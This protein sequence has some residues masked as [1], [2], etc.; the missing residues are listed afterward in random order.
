MSNIT[1][2][3]VDVLMPFLGGYNLKLTASEISK[4]M[5]IPQQTVSR[6]LN[7]LVRK[8]LIQYNKQ[9]KNKLFY[10]DLEKCETEVMLN[11][12]EN[13]KS[14]NFLNKT[15]KVGVIVG[16]LLKYCD[17]IILFGSYASYK[18]NENSDL[19]LVVF[20]PK[21]GFKKIVRQSVMDI[22]PHYTTYKEFK[23][24]IKGGNPLTIEILRNHILFG[25]VSKI[26]KNFIQNG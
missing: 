1:Q 20:K 23:K 12:I 18:N 3:W 17:S 5:K 11:I 6:L 7:Q 16:S 4:K 26:I 13:I 8:N 14:L 21:D 9:G 15:K 19:D 25:E 10:L 24:L 22:N 2:K